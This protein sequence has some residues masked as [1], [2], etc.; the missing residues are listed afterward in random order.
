MR[1][2]VKGLTVI[3]VAFVLALTVPS[4]M[5]ANAQVDVE[6]IAS[7][8]VVEYPDRINFTLELESREQ[9]TDIR[10]NYRVERDS[11]VDVVCE[12]VAG[13]DA[14]TKSASWTWDMYTTGNLPPGTVV[15]YWWK[16]ST[17]SGN[18]HF[19]QPQK[20]AFDDSRYQWQEI[21]EGNLSIYWYRGDL[22]FAGELMETARVALIQ[23]EDDMGAYLARPVNIY[24]YGSSEDLQGAMLYVQE[25]AGGLAFTGYG[26]VAIGIAPS[27]IDWGKRAMVH[28]LA[29]LVTHQMTNNPYNSIPV[30][31]NEGISMYAE[32]EMEEFSESY[33][34]RA[35][36]NNDLI[37]VQSLASPF[38]SDADITYLSYAQSYSLVEYLISQHGS[39]KMGELLYTFSLGSTY[40]G[41]FMNVF[42][43]D[44][45]GLDTAWQAWV[46]EK[47]SASSAQRMAALPSFMAVL[48]AVLMASSAVKS[49]RKK[50]LAV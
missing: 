40:D 43:F 36:A 28:E 31:L 47:Y 8:A 15:E 22:A 29:H 44:I 13:Y 6:T 38:S 33:L 14:D 9:I 25:W 39:Q 23:L 1:V 50:R 16:I 11:F 34:R 7:Y 30:W 4:A 46:K 42:G 26:V 32:G 48:L 37:S 2:R 18:Y 10:L 24:I 12:S 45:D 41:A 5:P 19:T 17:G 3:L 35:A 20:V 27:N 49:C 21:S